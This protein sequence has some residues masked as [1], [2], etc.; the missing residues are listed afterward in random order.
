VIQEVDEFMAFMA[1]GA[2]HHVA[3][4]DI[5]VFKVHIVRR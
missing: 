4:F 1:L 2:S 5:I 3:V